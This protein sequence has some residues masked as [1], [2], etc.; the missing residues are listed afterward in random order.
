[1]FSFFSFPPNADGWVDEGALCHKSGS[2]ETVAKRSY[3]RGA[4]YPMT[5]ADGLVEDAALCYPPCGKGFYG[6]G[7]VCWERCPVAQDYPV[8]GGAVCCRNKTVCT[9][10]V[11]DLSAGLP[12]AVMEAILSGGDPKKVEKSVLDALQSLLGFVMPKCDAT[13]SQDPKLSTKK[14]GSIALPPPS[15]L[16]PVIGVVSQPMSSEPG[17]SYIA[18]SYPKWIEM[19]G[20]R[21]VPLK[22]GDSDA[23]I[24]G[25]LSQLNGIVWPGGGA[26]ITHASSDYYKFASNIWRKALAL[27]DAGTYF[28]QWGTCLGFEFI[29]VMAAGGAEATGIDAVLQCDFDSEDLP[30]PL[31]FSSGAADSA[32]MLDGMPATLLRALSTEAL[33]QNEHKCGVPTGV[34]GGG[35][36]GNARLA[37]FFDVVATNVDRKGKPFVSMVE[38]KKYPVYGMQAHPEKSNF[39]WTTKEAL[40]IPHT[41]H[42]V[43]MSQWFA[44]FFVEEARRN[45]QQLKNA[46][47]ELIYKYTPTYTGA[48]GGYFEQV[49]SFSL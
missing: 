38:G 45:G 48:T 26:D 9:K 18:A 4:G 28:P 40:A 27:N 41:R 17:L 15:N 21:V 14:S 16:R 43:E 33:T 46:T 49:Y 7:P 31:N 35:V 19:A 39:E 25:I 44:T 47:D 3:G 8:D 37:S 13:D 5:C 12:L 11:L 34:Y 42:A 2:I 29:H 6:V 30:L 24:D 36:G 23:Y 22:M 10:K 20:A 1:M 32:R